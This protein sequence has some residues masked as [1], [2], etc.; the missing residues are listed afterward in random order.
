MTVLFKRIGFHMNLSDCNLINLSIKKFKISFVLNAKY[1]SYRDIADNGYRCICTWSLSLSLYRVIL[2]I[3]QTGVCLD[4]QL[5]L[6]TILQRF[7]N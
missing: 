3:L 4:T 7:T 1:Y 6:F 5:T 2:Y